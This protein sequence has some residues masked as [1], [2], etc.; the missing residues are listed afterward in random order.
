MNLVDL[1]RKR[2][3]IAF[4]SLSRSASIPSA[5][6]LAKEYQ[7]VKEK[8]GYWYVFFD[9]W[10]PNLQNLLY[11]V[12]GLKGSRLVEHGAITKLYRQPKNK[13]IDEPAKEQ[14]KIEIQSELS[15]KWLKDQAHKKIMKDIGNLQKKINEQVKDVEIQKEGYHKAR[16][17]AKGQLGALIILGCLHRYLSLLPFLGIPSIRWLDATAI[18]AILFLSLATIF[19]ILGLSRYK[20]WKKATKKEGKTK[21][22]RDDAQNILNELLR[23]PSPELSP[24]ILAPDLIG[25]LVEMGFR[26]KMEDVRVVMGMDQ[27]MFDAAIVDMAIELGFWIDGD[28]LVFDEG[29]TATFMDRVKLFNNKHVL[30]G[31]VTDAMN[32]SRRVPMKD[33]QEITRLEAR[34]LDEWVIDW[35]VQ[36]GFKIDG[37]ELVLDPEKGARFISVLQTFSP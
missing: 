4:N 13:P 25:V 6:R 17:E 15:Q 34:A 29:N 1:K 11:L 3:V 31:K 26:V 16:N 21:K 18:S 28:Y 19:L 32:G 33:I 22:D 36:F 23:K 7:H 20:D 12:D 30:I 5:L 27:A 35:A 8:D 37:D 2:F 9:S 10:D 24:G 14:P